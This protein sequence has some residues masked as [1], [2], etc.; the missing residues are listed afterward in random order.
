ME[1]FQRPL[2]P[3]QC[4]GL[5]L[6]AWIGVTAGGTVRWRPRR[7]V[8]LILLV[9]LWRLGLSGRFGPPRTRS[10][11]SCRCPRPP[12]IILTIHRRVRM[13]FIS[14]RH[15]HLWI[16]VVSIRRRVRRIPITLM[17]RLGRIRLLTSITRCR[18]RELR[19][20][21]WI[22]SIWITTRLAWLE[23]ESALLTGALSVWRQSCGEFLVQCN[24]WCSRKR[25]FPTNFVEVG[26]ASF[27]WQSFPWIDQA[28]HQ[29]RKLRASSQEALMIV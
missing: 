7:L 6:V 11:V 13:L 4:G 8:V 19:V 25:I 23:S 21:R 3:S 9:H 17:W 2:R 18:R 16:G 5:F 15:H 26:L 12:R 27:I 20:G 1:T 28:L 10:I 29:F 14:L 24:S 22:I